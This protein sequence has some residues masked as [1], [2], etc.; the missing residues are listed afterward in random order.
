VS[1]SSGRLS[2]AA[3]KLHEAREALAGAGAGLGADDRAELALLCEELRDLGWRAQRLARRNE[4]D[5]ELPRDF[6]KYDAKELEAG[7]QLLEAEKQD[8]DD[9]ARSLPPPKAGRGG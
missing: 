5:A 4:S 3:W 6:P 2:N 8:L 1:A 9:R 7:R